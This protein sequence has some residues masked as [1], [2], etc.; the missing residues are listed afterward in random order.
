M[1][2]V[3]P[4]LPKNSQNFLALGFVA[5]GRT[6]AWEDLGGLGR[7]WDLGTWGPGAWDSGPGIWGLGPGLAW[8]LE[9]GC[10]H[11]GYDIL[12]DGWMPLFVN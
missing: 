12:S 5:S 1:V 3:A 10:C 2:M 11:D 6:W 8:D 9:A 7:T 4:I